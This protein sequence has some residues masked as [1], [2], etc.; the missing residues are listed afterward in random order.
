MHKELPILC[1]QLALQQKVKTE[2]SFPPV[3]MNFSCCR[4]NNVSQDALNT[5]QGDNISYSAD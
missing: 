5:E 4:K 1:Y 3:S 2:K